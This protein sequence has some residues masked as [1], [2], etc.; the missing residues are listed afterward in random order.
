MKNMLSTEDITNILKYYG[1]YMACYS[2]YMNDMVIRGEAEKFG[3]C[4]YIATL[5]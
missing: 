5:K 3:G 1:N 4:K 2:A